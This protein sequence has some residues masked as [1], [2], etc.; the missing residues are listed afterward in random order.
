MQRAARPARGAAGAPGERRDESRAQ[1]QIT[2]G[3]IPGSPC[4]L[5]G[6]WRLL[7]RVSARLL[8]PRELDQ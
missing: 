1:R 7:R 2:P 8:T 5:G 3:E 6:R 4:L